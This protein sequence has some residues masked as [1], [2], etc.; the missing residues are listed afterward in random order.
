MGGLLDCQLLSVCPAILAEQL[1]DD[2]DTI[3]AITT[4]ITNGKLT[5][6]EIEVFVVELTELL[7]QRVRKALK[8]CTYKAL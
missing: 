2:A 8:R 7:R 4:A 6:T 1:K 5:K 3:E